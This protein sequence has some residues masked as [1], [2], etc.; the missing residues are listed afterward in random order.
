MSDPAGDRASVLRAMEEFRQ[1]GGHEFVR[2]MTELLR[3]QTPE[4]FAQIE[5]ALATNDLATALR[6]AHSMK[7][8]FGNFGVTECQ[9]LATAMELA[10]KQARID[11]YRS[12]FQKLRE[13]FARLQPILDDANQG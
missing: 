2:E 13:A 3:T 6:H 9:Q 5:A 7:S 12:E 8:S 10:G 11:D 1:L 4:Q